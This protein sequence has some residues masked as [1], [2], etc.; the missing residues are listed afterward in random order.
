MAALITSRHFGKAAQRLLFS[1]ADLRR[2][3]RQVRVGQ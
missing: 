3:D 1:R 2:G